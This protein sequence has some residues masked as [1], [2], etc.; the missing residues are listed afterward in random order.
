[1]EIINVGWFG[2]GSFGYPIAENLLNRG[3]KLFPYTF[4]N[5]GK[6]GVQRLVENYNITREI[7]DFENL[8]ILVFCL[9]TSNDVESILDFYELKLPKII[10]DLTTGDP[11]K[12]KKISSNLRKQGILYIDAP[13]S[14]SIETA[15]SGNL[16]VFAGADDK[17]IEN[18]VKI[19]LES[20]G[21]V[22]YFK[23]PGNGHTA[24]LIN[25][26]I[27]LSN[28]GILGEAFKLAKF[29][30]LELQE[31]ADALK[32][33]SANSKMLER[34]GDSIIKE[35]FKPFFNLKLANKDIN[36]VNN[37]NKNSGNQLAYGDI[38]KALLNTKNSEG[39]GES[40][41]TIICK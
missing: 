13:V 35:D 10:I 40:N 33:S 15:R 1:M 41:F 19:F 29:C 12:S 5:H 25:Q 36:L 37:L 30:G 34:F 2:L 28:V 14:G 39:F 4:K 24:K 22:F 32:T 7:V 20:L 6:E 9:P 8:D 3:Y 11:E 38:T 31:L 17:M 26:L 27:H 21:K 23:Q 16:T 18:S